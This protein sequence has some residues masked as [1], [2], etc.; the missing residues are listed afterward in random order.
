MSEYVSECVIEC[1]G[2]W[3]KESAPLCVGEGVVS[4]CV[5]EFVDGWVGE[6]ECISM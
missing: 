2:G 1:V 4:E 6:S 5:G 3:L